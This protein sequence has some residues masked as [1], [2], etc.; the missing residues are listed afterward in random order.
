MDPSRKKEQFSNAFIAAIASKCGF[1]MSKPDVD[2]DSIDWTLS[3]KG[4][5]GS[6]RSPKL[7]IQ[8]KCTALEL[9]IE[10]DFSFDL[11]V[12]NFND[13]VPSHVMVP[14]ILVVVLVPESE[15][16]WLEQTEEELKIRRC[17]YWVSL[18]GE[19][20]STNASSVTIRLPRNQMFDPDG[21]NTIFGRLETG[22]LP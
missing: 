4:G 1:R 21:L 18:R 8:L 12:K 11:K 6:V 20:E 2:D 3:G 13:L 22:G 19:S 7:D 15:N 9:G 17:G 5:S 10:N 16:E 14:R